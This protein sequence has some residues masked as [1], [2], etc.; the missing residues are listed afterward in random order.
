MQK[1]TLASAGLACI[2]VKERGKKER[3]GRREKKRKGIEAQRVDPPPKP[4]PGIDSYIW[5]EEQNG[6]QKKEQ[7]PILL[8]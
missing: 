5:D 2:N 7:F 1:P 6:K 8:G 3:H 4:I